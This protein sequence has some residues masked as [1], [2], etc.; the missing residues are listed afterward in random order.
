M[1]IKISI[2]HWNLMIFPQHL[3]YRGLRGSSI[4]IKGHGPPFAYHV[5]NISALVVL[6][7]EMF[8]A[9]WRI[10]K[11]ISC[12]ASEPTEELWLGLNDLKAHLYFEWSDGTP[13]TFTKWQRRHPTNTNGLEHCVT[14]KGQV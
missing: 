8:T 1:F 12:H 2:S 11:P 4:F 10:T 14:M 5:P 6:H 9:Q 13:V 3:S 7:M